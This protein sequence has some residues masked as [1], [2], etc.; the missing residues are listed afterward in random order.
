MAREFEE[1]NGKKKKQKDNKGEKE[2]RGRE[3]KEKRRTKQN[4]GERDV[5]GREVRQTR[6][7]QVVRGR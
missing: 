1:G 5:R 2:M 3:K 6:P 4:K 7:Q